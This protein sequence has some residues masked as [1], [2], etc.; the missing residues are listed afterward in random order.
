MRR[1][2]AGLGEAPRLLSRQAAERPRLALVAARRRGGEKLLEREHVVQ[3][4]RESAADEVAVLFGGFPACEVRAGALH[5][6]GLGAPAT[7][8]ARQVE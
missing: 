8:G 1:C 2:A 4:L 5:Y 6:L 3:E 7:G